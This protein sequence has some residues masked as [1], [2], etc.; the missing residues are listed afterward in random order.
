MRMA[1]GQVIRYRQKLT[2]AGYE[3]VTAIIATE[4]QP[5]DSSWEDLCADE[6]IVLISPDTAEKTLRSE[7]E[8]PREEEH[9]TTEKGRTEL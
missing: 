6:D 7:C 1:I 4:K 5:S 8:R 3:P 9:T 2:A